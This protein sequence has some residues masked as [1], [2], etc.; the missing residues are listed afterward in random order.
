[1]S[2]AKIKELETRIKILEHLVS[3]LTVQT[4]KKVKVKK[5]KDPDAPKR[6]PNA[7][8]FFVREMKKL[9]PKTDMKE[10]GRMWREDFLR[11]MTAPPGPRWPLKLR[12]L[13]RK[14]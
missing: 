2:D 6:A 10:L 9:E 8:N 12:I 14:R 13:T 7:Y 5:A 3:T 11:R 1:M 4:T